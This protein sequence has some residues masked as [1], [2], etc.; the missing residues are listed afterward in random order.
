MASSSDGTKLVAVATFNQIYRSSDSGAT[1]TAFTDWNL[2]RHWVKV[3][4]S[5]D[6]TKLVAVLFTENADEGTT[7]LGCDA[8]ELLGSPN[9]A[10]GL[11]TCEV[12]V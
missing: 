4:S 9:C 2:Y 3:A 5:S 8:D 12:S 6:G 11:Y 1:W 10:G 7:F